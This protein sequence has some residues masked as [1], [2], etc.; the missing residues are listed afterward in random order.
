MPPGPPSPGGSPPPPAPERYAEADVEQADPPREKLLADEAANRRLVATTAALALLAVA[1]M[2]GVFL[3]T[4]D[5]AVEDPVPEAAPQATIP[6]PTTVEAAPD[7]DQAE[8]DEVI[9]RVQRFVAQE[10]GLEFTEDVEVV[11]LGRQAYADRVR[12]T[13][14]AT[15]DDVSGYLAQHASVYQALGLWPA[16]TDPISVTREVS[17]LGSV[18]FYDPETQQA[19]IGIGELSPLFEVTL[20]HELAHALD[21]QHFRLDRPALYGQSDEVAAAFDA[22]AEGDAR[23][24][25]LAY[26]ATLGEEERQSVDEDAAAA[27]PDFDPESVPPILLYEQQI[28]YDDG[29]TF[30]QA[31][32]DEGG[33]A[34]VDR[35]FEDPPTTTEEILEPATYLDGPPPASVPVPEAD[36]EPFA[37]GVIGQAVLDALTAFDRPAEDTIPEW[38]GDRYVLWTD[39]SNAVCI[40]FRV[41]GD[42]PGFEEQLQTWAGEV[43]AEVT[44][45][46]GAVVATTCH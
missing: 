40:R 32:L 45:E 16:G 34:A 20:A 17:A 7:I 15:L 21:D 14:D 30:V 27:T 10:R 2:I 1:V 37:E 11:V 23:R 41:D 9:E 12:E 24:I 19:V 26:Q 33:N 5:G 3:L 28:A 38:N 39:E 35:A 44:V 6:T 4:D 13:F 36:G 31:L 18:G 43:G 29:Q 46:G 22:L 8:L 25:E 42:A